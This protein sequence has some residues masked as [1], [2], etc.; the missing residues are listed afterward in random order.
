MLKVSPVRR[1]PCIFTNFFYGLHELEITYGIIKHVRVFKSKFK[2]LYWYRIHV[3]SQVFLRKLSA[4]TCI[5]SQSFFI[6]ILKHS[7]NTKFCATPNYNFNIILILLLHAF[8]HFIKRH[9]NQIRF[10]ASA[11]ELSAS[12]TKAVHIHTHGILKL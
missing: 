7:N 10:L 12:I 2:K 9:I 8:L 5:V 3:F 4:R 6:G 1:Q 11:N